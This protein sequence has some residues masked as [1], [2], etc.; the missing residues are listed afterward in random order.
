MLFS[1][2]FQIPLHAGGK[3]PKGEVRKQTNSFSESMH[4]RSCRPFKEGPKPRPGKVPK[5]VLRKVPAPNR[6][7]RKVP[8]KCFG[9]SFSIESKEVQFRTL[10]APLFTTNPLDRYGPGSFSSN[11]NT[12][13]V[14]VAMPTLAGCVF[15]TYS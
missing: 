7:P 2:C 12:W 8:K 11:A 10:G 3:A 5:R 15:F 9:V 1:M 4:L 14:R 6:V 13:V